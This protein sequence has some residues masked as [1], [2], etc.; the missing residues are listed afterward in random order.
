[1]KRVLCYGDSNTYGLNPHTNLRYSEKERW[2][3]ILQEI[4]GNEYAVIEEGL[5]GRTTV[6]S[7]PGMEYRNGY[8]Y[9]E[10]CL[11][12]HIPVDYLIFMLGTNDTKILFGKEP[13]EIAAQ[14]RKLIETAQRVLQEDNTK[15]CKIL[16][17]SP[18]A[19]GDKVADGPLGH[20]FDAESAR[21][22]KELSFYYKKEAEL[23]GIDFLDLAQFV[24]SS[25][26]DGIHLSV[27]AHKIIAERISIWIKG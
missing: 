2:T 7:E 4:L 8:S 26:I 3:G 1:M 5:N 23:A 24:E 15:E 19:L 14:M 13:K 12:T 20:E 11:L 21:K 27:D 10:P 25:D 9:L 18:A 17:V 22:S 16:L 6:L